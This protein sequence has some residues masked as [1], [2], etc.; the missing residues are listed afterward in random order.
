M[1]WLK[2]RKNRFARVDKTLHDLA[3]WNRHAITIC[4]CIF[5]T[6]LLHSSA[7]RSPGK[8]T[9]STLGSASRNFAAAMAFLKWRSIRRCSVFSPRLH[10]KQS[11]GDGTQPRAGPGQG[12][13]G[14]GGKRK[15]QKQMVR[16]ERFLIGAELCSHVKLVNPVEISSLGNNHL[17]TQIWIKH[18]SR[19]LTLH[20]N[21]TRCHSHSPFCRNFSRSY[22]SSRFI[23][24][25][26][27]T[28]SLC[29]DKSNQCRKDWSLI[30]SECQSHLE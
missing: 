29:P 22:R 5:K 16:S 11:K 4:C 8:T 3:E 24:A 18:P 27:I 14:E 28:T 6:C 10:R 13:M 2:W 30:Q 1:R 26:P 23:E 25:R 9:R 20:H 17:L 7:E 15:K 19:K 12:H 21:V